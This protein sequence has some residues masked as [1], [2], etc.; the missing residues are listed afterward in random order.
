MKFLQR[1]KT[2]VPLPYP[3]YFV[4]VILI[5]LIGLFDSIYL[6]I[7]HYRNYADIGYQSFCA[8]SRAINCD[9]VSQS[10]YSIFLDVPIPIWGIMGYAFSL[11]LILFSWP[12][13]AA[14]KRVWSFLLVVSLS[15]C[16]YSIIL[17]GI[18]MFLIHSYC[19]MCILSYVVCF[20]MLYYVWIIRK[21][22]ACDGIFSGI[23]LDILYLMHFPKI[24][25]SIMSLF[26][27]G[28][29]LLFAFLPR[30]WDMMPP[31]LPKD[32]PRGITEDGHPWIGAE[33]PELVIV[34]FTDYMCFQCKKMHFHLR[35]IVQNNPDKIRLVHR[36]FPMD[37]KINPIVKEPFHIGS[38]QLS[39]LAIYGAEKGK[40]WE[41]NDVLF[42]LP[43]KGTVNIRQVAEKSGLD[44][45][46]MR[47]V[48]HKK[49]IWRILW[50]DIS[51]GLNKYQ[52]SGTPGYV[53][54]D[55]VYLGQIPPGIL[56]NYVQ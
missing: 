24:S 34:E 20:F 44:Y 41:I 48:F 8:L 21:R 39:L 14:R 3:Y 28:I 27:A 22:F 53:I 5:T 46:E 11:V 54:N 52:L 10:P 45:E 9:T 31:V 38:A 17:A 56:K 42:N 36:H 37:N 23:R 12:V 40:F 2:I 35:R 55:R 6:A 7:S 18:S 29:V 43:R 4:P 13:A 25:L 30:Y 49:K 16:I 47:Y 51:E 19:I 32:I 50:K 1:K 15:F 33:H 26:A